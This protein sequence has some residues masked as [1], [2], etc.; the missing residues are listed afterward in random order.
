VELLELK[1][2]LKADE[3]DLDVNSVENTEILDTKTA[4][5]E[6]FIGAGIATD[7]ERELYTIAVKLLTKHWYE[8]REVTGTAGKL[9]YSLQSI[10]TQLQN[11]QIVPPIIV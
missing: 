1:I 11:T 8:G 9:A 5:E 4:V 3:L 7:Y 10:I 6:Y 2:Y